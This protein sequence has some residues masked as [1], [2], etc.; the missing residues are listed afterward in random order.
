M[1]KISVFLIFSFSI[2]LFGSN[3]EYLEPGFPVTAHHTAGSYQSGPNLLTLVGNIDEDPELEIMATGLAQGPVYAWNYDGTVVDGFPVFNGYS[4]AGY[5][6][7]GY[8]KVSENSYKD[9]LLCVGFSD[10]SI[11]LFKG[12]GST[13]NG[14]PVSTSNNFLSTMPTIEIFENSDNPNND[15]FKL[16]IG[17]EDW[18]MYGFHSDGSNLDGWP[19]GYLQTQ[20]I[21]SPSYADIDGD[22]EIEIVFCSGYSSGG[23][24]LYVYNLDGTLVDGFPIIYSMNPLVATYPVIGDVNGDSF[25]EIIIITKGYPNYSPYVAKIFSHEGELLLE[26][27]LEGNISYVSAPALADLGGDEIPEIIVQTEAAL[28]IFDSDGND[29]PNFPVVFSG[30]NYYQGNSAPVI[31]DVDGDDEMEIVITLDKISSNDGEVRVYNSD[32]TIDADKIITIPIGGGAVPAIAD[33]DLDGRNEVIVS[34]SFWDG[35][36]GDY[37]KCWAYDFGGE[38]HGSIEW[39]QMG[40][41]AAH[42]GRYPVL[43]TSTSV[44]ID[45]SNCELQITNYE[46]KQNYPNPFNP[47][48]KINYELRISNYELAEI[49]VHNSAGQKVWSSTI[50]SSLFTNH[51]TFDGSKFNS[52]IYYYS[53]VIDGKKIDSKS[54]VLIK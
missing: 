28:N 38:N 4:A 42:S 24:E 46:L 17:A 25:N 31:G 21:I 11:S 36:S 2:I 27:E 48:T 53:L 13:V 19:S 35:Y 54:M 3:R 16:L 7:L 50:H 30:G 22:E 18:K 41:N 15:I 14:W 47:V 8:K 52:G 12:D 39:G 34:G 23:G 5:L 33:I 26:K 1:F 49:V 32:G 10:G 6:S 45:E 51:C 29:F 40:G 20:R 44:D 43:Q 37:D 9:T